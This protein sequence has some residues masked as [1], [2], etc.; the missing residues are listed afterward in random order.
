MLDS[1]RKLDRNAERRSL[2]ELPWN[3]F[4][5]G[6]I[7][8]YS[9]T[10]NLYQLRELGVCGTLAQLIASRGYLPTV[11]SQ[12]Y[13][14]NIVLGLEFLHTWGIM[15]RDIKPANLFI[16]GDGYLMIGDL[17]VSAHI[18]DETRWVETGTLIYSPPEVN[19][20]GSHAADLYNQHFEKRISTDWWGAAVVLYEMATNKIVRCPL[21]R[22]SLLF[23]LTLNVNLGRGKHG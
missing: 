6:L 18:S 10:V 8:A 9:D 13:F 20:K 1:D 4:V 12:F 5:A 19:Y 11:W 21:R 16:G 7:D 17:G 23:W 22:F 2:W 14:S 15:H 3:P